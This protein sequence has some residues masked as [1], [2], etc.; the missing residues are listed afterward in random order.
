MPPTVRGWTRLE[1]YARSQ[2]LQP[3]LQAQV[4]DPLWLLSRQW[5]LGEFWGEDAGSPVQ[6]WLRMDCTP[7]TRYLPA[8]IPST[9][10][11][12]GTT[13]PNTTAQGRHLERALPLETV[14]ER[15]HVHLE[16]T[17]RPRLA[18]EAGLHF[19]RLLAARGHGAHRGAVLARFPLTAS[20][21]GAQPLDAEA[22]RFLS[23][24]AGR[25]PDGTLLA[26]VLRVVRTPATLDVLREPYRSRVAAGVQAWQAWQGTLP[27]ADRTRID[28]VVTD[29]LR[30]YDTLFSEP[31]ATS[32]GASGGASWVAERME[33]EF[34]AAT[35]MPQGEV[36]L[37]APEYSEGHL[38]WY[39]FD[40]LPAG[41]LGAARG[42]LSA[43]DLEREA[44]RQIVIPTPVH[45]PG[46]PAARYWEFED[47]RVDFGAIA[48]D[49][50]Q[51][52]HLLLV[53]FA[54]VGG[55]DWFVIP[56]DAPVG[57]LCRV[58]W[59]VVT[60]TFGERTLVASARDVD[61]PLAAGQR[62]LPWDMFRLSP[63]PRPVPG[64]RRP[65]PDALFLPPVL[66]AS[67]HGNALDEVLLLRDEMANMAWAVERVVESPT[68]RPRDRA[69]AYYRARR[70]DQA[71][72]GTATGPVD[73]QRPPIYRLATEVPEHWL[74]LYPMRP[75]ANL[76]AIRLLRG[77]TPQGRLLEPERTP[78]GP[79]PLRLYEEEV[80]REGAH[81][82]RAFQYTRGTD[83]RTYLW[84]GRRK[85]AGRGEGSSGLRFDVLESADRATS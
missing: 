82:T 84:L 19:Q 5:Q 2:G 12:T 22:R 48:A 65:M 67:L 25:V 30:W 72:A 85:G 1:P 59:L 15:E 63:D 58:R 26:S 49:A 79:N 38:D 28:G 80:P 32:G 73:G 16:G 78:E 60:N 39:S 74:P 43:A 55:D 54:L 20:A 46:M 3:G 53:E 70:R 27:A 31:G 11:Q 50:Q 42:D 34:A 75:Q 21:A 35:P 77:G 23:V 66:A 37:T 69:E 47:A 36:L 17:L 71:E 41:S 24:T 10:Y 56:V 76:P 6:A 33:Y 81:V 7:L 29:W 18:A 64:T 83:G 45:Y 40:V 51:L 14:V 4:H 57:S 8:G 52:A 62:R 13:A 9:W 44:V 68:G 61:A